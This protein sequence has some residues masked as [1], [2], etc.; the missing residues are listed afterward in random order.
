MFPTFLPFL[1]LRIATLSPPLSTAVKWLVYLR[2]SRCFRTSHLS[3]FEKVSRLRCSAFVISSTRFFFDFSDF[4]SSPLLSLLLD[5]RSWSRSLL[6]VLEHEGRLSHV[7]QSLC[8]ESA[9]SRAIQQFPPSSE[10]LEERAR[11]AEHHEPCRHLLSVAADVTY[12]VVQQSLGSHAFCKAAT[13]SYCAD[14]TCPQALHSHSAVNRSF[15]FF[16]GANL[17]HYKTS[18]T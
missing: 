3:P 17:T 13:S 4:L 2:L 7:V 8:V 11:A 1:P 5:G 18:T 14:S 12:L 15:S 9:T 10:D 16:Q 6:T